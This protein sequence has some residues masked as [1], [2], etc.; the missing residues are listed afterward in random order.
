L[1]SHT[2]PE[3]QHF[4]KSKSK[5]CQG[6]KLHILGDALCGL[7]LALDVTPGGNHDSTQAHPLIARAKAL[8]EDLS[9][10]LADAAYG[11]MPVRREVYDGV[12]VTLLAPP[13]SRKGG[14]LGRA[15]FDIDFDRMVATCPGGLSTAAWK[16]AKQS[17]EVTQAFFWLKGSESECMCSETCPVHKPRKGKGGKQSTPSRRLLLHPQEQKLRT[18]RA[19][20]E[21]PEVRQ[22]YRQRS[23]GERLINEMTR[24]GA[25]R[26]NAWGIDNARLQ[27]YCIAAV[28][29]L[30]LLSRKLAEGT[31]QQRAA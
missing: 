28:N 30:K 14:G 4:R 15:D 9:E 1:I 29:N 19:D 2:D 31:T 26:A 27:A 25:R 16:P 17:G 13:L 5:V 20:W 12:G 10:V 23:Q 8:Y 7:I 21:Q 6:F 18:V 22:R 3:A 11:G 24:R